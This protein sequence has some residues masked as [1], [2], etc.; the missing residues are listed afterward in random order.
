[1]NNV[2]QKQQQPVE[3]KKPTPVTYAV[4]RVEIV[5]TKDAYRLE[6]EM[7]GVGKDG[8]EVSLDGNELTI[9][10]RRSPSALTADYLYR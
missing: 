6:A 7:P 9:L 1:M 4:P 2:I 3:A 5:E 10:G 8:L